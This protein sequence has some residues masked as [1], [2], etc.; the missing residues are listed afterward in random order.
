MSLGLV[1]L[2]MDYVR[3]PKTVEYIHR[4]LSAERQITS[5]E[6]AQLT[7]QRPPAGDVDTLRAS[8]G[9]PAGV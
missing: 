9:A 8:D 3:R 6:M 7:A 5:D 2:M 1:V 4:A